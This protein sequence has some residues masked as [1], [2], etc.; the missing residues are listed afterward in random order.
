MSRPLAWNGTTWTDPSFH[1][2]GGQYRKYIPPVWDDPV[3]NAQFASS[4]EGFSGTW[5]GSE[6]GYIHTQ[7]SPGFLTGMGLGVGDSTELYRTKNLE[8]AVGHYVQMRRLVR[9]RTLVSAPGGTG[10]SGEIMTDE[11]SIGGAK[12]QQPDDNR[13]I[14]FGPA[15]WDSGWYW[16]HINSSSPIAIP[17]YGWASDYLFINYS[18][19]TGPLGGEFVGWMAWAAVELWDL[20][21]GQLLMDLGDPGWQPRVYRS[22][23]QWV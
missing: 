10:F 13:Y 4:A 16:E 11:F 22:N 15:G 19:Y 6:G 2:G 20:N 7:N 8:P 1:I 12:W 21:T 23:G 9:F 14:E 17:Y 5:E 18:V 3:C